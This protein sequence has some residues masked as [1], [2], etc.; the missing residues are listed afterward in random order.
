MLNKS[1]LSGLNEVT[2]VVWKRKPIASSAL[3]LPDTGMSTGLKG[4]T[5]KGKKVV[6]GALCLQSIDL[7]VV[8]KSWAFHR[9]GEG[10]AENVYTS[11]ATFQSAFVGLRREAGQ[12]TESRP[13]RQCGKG[14]SA[15][16]E[17]VYLHGEIVD[18][19]LT[20]FPN[21]KSH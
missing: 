17:A 8:P 5:G 20:P 15:R 21:T 13:Q 9:S 12:G 3:T 18:V 11:P 16:I 14:H 6:L 1:R 2:E 19:S 4:K 7:K 10:R